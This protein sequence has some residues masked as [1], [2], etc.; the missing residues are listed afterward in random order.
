MLRQ[1]L[2][3]SLKEAMRAKDTRALATIRLILAALK[4]RDIQARTE[5][6]G[7]GVGEQEILEMLQKMVRQRR[8]AIELY[9][10]GQRQDLVQREEEEI[11][12]IERFLPKPLDET[13]SEQA[14]SAAIDELE[15]S[16]IKDMGRVMALLKER[17]PG[18]MDFARAS[19]Q[20]KSRLG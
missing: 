16:T 1:Q 7:D 4:D 18:R 20:V 10:K 13:E 6:Q 14:V 15:A 17:F 8:D 2:N 5:G 9:A 19:Q 12:V 11:A 3:D